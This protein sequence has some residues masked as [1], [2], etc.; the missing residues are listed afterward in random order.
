MHEETY[1]IHKTIQG[2]CTGLFAFL[3][4]VSY[5]INITA[6]GDIGSS[7]T[8]KIQLGETLHAHFKNRKVELQFLHHEYWHFS[9]YNI[10][11]KNATQDINYMYDTCDDFST[12]IEGIIFEDVTANQ[13]F[14]Q[15]N[16]FI[17]IPQCYRENRKSTN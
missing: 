6:D 1:I 10:K 9:Q 5:D 8:S 4:L 2:K 17:C 16:D 7:S 3:H 11:Q 15:E 13:C 12:K 14:T